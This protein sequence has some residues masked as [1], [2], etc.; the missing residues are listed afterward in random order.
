MGIVSTAYARSR[1]QRWV[2]RKLRKEMNYGPVVVL[3]PV[4][5]LK[6]LAADVGP[7][8]FKELRAFVHEQRHHGKDRPAL[9]AALVRFEE[10]AK[11]ATKFTR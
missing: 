2:P 6:E 10:T 1:E 8:N 7:L 9:E 11:Y 4:R 5:R 3:H